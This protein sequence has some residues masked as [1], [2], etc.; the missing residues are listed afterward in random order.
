MAEGARR[1]E[2]IAQSAAVALAGWDGSVRER[3]GQRGAG[4]GSSRGHLALTLELGGFPRRRFALQ[5]LMY[6]PEPATPR[7]GLVLSA[8]PEAKS[9]WS[10]T[11]PA[12]WASAETRRSTPVTCWRGCSGSETR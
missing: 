4:E 5:S 12:R 2:R 1:S 7:D 11:Y 3:R 10:L 8:T 9:S 6:L